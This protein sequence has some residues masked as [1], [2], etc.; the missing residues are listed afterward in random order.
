[1]LCLVRYLFVISSSVIDCLGR[2]V[3]EMTYYV[4]SGTLNLINLPTLQI[5]CPFTIV[6][7]DDY[8]KFL[9]LNSNDD[10]DIVTCILAQ[11]HTCGY[12]Q[13]IIK[14]IHYE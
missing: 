11:I 9:L 12:R 2:F 13:I 1:M 6:I 3:S 8:K 7:A 10:D 5:F 14:Y 4:S